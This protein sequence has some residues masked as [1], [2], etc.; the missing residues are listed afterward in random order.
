[1][2]NTNERN[3]PSRLEAMSAQIK[4]LEGTMSQKLAQADL[5][6]NNL[7]NT[8]DKVEVQAQETYDELSVQYAFALRACVDIPTCKMINSFC[9]YHGVISI[10]DLRGKPLKELNTLMIAFEKLVSVYSAVLLRA[11]DVNSVDL[12][13][14]DKRKEYDASMRAFIIREDH[15]P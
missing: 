1:M 13:K 11:F 14:D 6:L 4:E 10:F 15:Y 8:L 2:D 7:K 9:V 5:L 3:T 12:L